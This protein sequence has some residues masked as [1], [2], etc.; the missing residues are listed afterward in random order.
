MRDNI[1]FLL[2]AGCSIQSGCM[3]A[4]KLV[5]EFKRRIFCST[6]GIAYS[7]NLFFK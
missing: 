4:N 1:S 6:E 3:G 2:G 5:N 7:E